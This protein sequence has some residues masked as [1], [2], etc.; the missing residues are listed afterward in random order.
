MDETVAIPQFKSAEFALAF[1]EQLQGVF[2]CSVIGRATNN[3]NRS[4]DF[5]LEKIAAHRLHSDLTDRVTSGTT[6]RTLA[7]LCGA[8]VTYSREAREIFARLDAPT[9]RCKWVY[10]NPLS[11]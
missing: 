2:D 6:A 9:R 3:F 4:D 7:G 11:N 10:R 8:L 1:L 5:I